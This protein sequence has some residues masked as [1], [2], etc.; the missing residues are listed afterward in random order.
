M[1]E[2]W[3]DLEEEPFEGPEPLSSTNVFR[4]KLDRGVSDTLDRLE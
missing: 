2:L 4:F 3:L 1:E